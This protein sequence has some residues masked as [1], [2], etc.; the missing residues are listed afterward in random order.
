M[1]YENVWETDGVYRKFSGK[2]TGDEILES[3]QLVEADS[4]F[5]SIRYVINDF[6]D[7]TEVDVSPQKIKTVAVID[8]AATLSNPD[9]VLAQVTTNPKVEDVIA[10][11]AQAPCPHAYP[12]KIFTR[13]ELAREWVSK[14]IAK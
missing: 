14:E 12:F 2:L 8:S 3:V 5:D 13:L 7:V 9:I 10:R 6:L 11:Y 1:S 4:R